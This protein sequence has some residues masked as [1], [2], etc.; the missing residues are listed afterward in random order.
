MRELFGRLAPSAWGGTNLI[1]VEE[2]FNYIAK[3]NIAIKKI[4]EW[5][6]CNTVQDF[7]RIK[8]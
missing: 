8:E 6:N 1:F 3:D 5:I 4:D 2:Y 7:L